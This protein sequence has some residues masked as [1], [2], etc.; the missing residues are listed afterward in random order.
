[1]PQLRTITLTVSSE[2]QEQEKI[3]VKLALAFAP[4]YENAQNRFY[5]CM[6]ISE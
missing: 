6:V 3:V 4:G 5:V 2:S 1:M